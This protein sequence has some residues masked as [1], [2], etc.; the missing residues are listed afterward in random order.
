MQLMRYRQS[1]SG[2]TAIEILITLAIISVILAI[3]VPT[4]SEHRKKVM[5][6]ECAKDLVMISQRLEKYH[7]FNYEY[8]EYLVDMGISMEDPWGNPIQYL[9]L[10]DIDPVSGAVQ[11]GSKGPKPTPRK[12]QNLKP[13][14]TDYDLFCVGPNG[15]YMPNISHKDSLDDVMRADDGAFLGLAADY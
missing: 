13:L 15:V 6:A 12:K 7:S 10:S 2:F 5:N 11:A 4:Y 9:N 14:N 1:G 8:P 3:G